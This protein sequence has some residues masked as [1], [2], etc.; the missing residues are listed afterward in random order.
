M[1]ITRRITFRLYPSPSQAK[2]L[3]YWRRLHKDLYNAAI[4]NRKNQYKH[5]KK[6]VDYYEQQNCLPEFKEVWYEYKQLGSHALQAT[7]KRVDMAFQRFFKGLGGYP[8]FKSIRH[9]SGWTYPCIAGWKALTNGNNGHL[10]LSN[11]GKIQMRGSARTWGKPTTC[12]VVNRQ[13]IWYASITVQC[14]PVRE[15]GTEAVGLDFGC[16]TVVAMSN[17]NIVENPRYLSV[18]QAKIKLVSKSKRRKTKPDF[19]QNIIASR[20]WKKAT[21]KV[22]KLQRKVSNQR[23]N[24]V[25]QVAAEIV[26]CNSLVA[27]EKLNIKAMTRH[28]LKGSKRKSQKTGLN[29]SILDVGMAMLKQ[30]IEYK[31]S[32]GGGIFVEVPTQKLKPS[33]T[34]PKCGSQKKKEL[35][36]RIHNCPCGFT[37][38]R[39]VAAAMVMLDWATGAGTVLDKRGSD[40]STSTHCGGFK[41]LAEMKRQKPPPSS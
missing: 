36:E 25:H 7:L 2:T 13:G 22:R 29:R 10:E 28:S 19:K 38:D 26:S 14:N 1:S 30:S 21:Q 4:A 24:W 5:F 32:E 37:C 8:K 3:G 34:C 18:T 11:L 20:R 33:Q 41:Q 35:S 39:D 12:T 9:Y 15:T 6:S 31:L 17:G 27:T 16:L 40:S 23:S